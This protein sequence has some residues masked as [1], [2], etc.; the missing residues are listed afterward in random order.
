M[1]AIDIRRAGASVGAAWPL[2]LSGALAAAA[3]IAAAELFAGLVA[4]APSLVTA[5]GA[6]VISLQ[7]PAPRSW[8]SRSS[9]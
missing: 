2:A 7:P 3:A 1:T 8:R 6:L 5:M 4:G 9:A